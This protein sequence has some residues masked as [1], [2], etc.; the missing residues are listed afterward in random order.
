MLE[1]FITTTDVPLLAALVLGFLVAINPCQ[2][3]INISALTYIIKKDALS[4]DKWTNPL[5]YVLG[6]SITYTLMAW[7]LV[8]LIGG[9]KNI[10]AVQLALS[11]GEDIL[12]YAL[13]LMALFFLY[14]GLHTHHHEHGDDCHNCG[15]IIQRNGPLGALTL[16]LTLALAFC[17]ESAVF[18][19]GL[20]LPMSATSS[21]GLL[22]PPVFAIGAALP[23]FFIAFVM[24]K[25]T[26]K[27]KRLSHSLEHLQRVLNIVTALLFLGIALFILFGE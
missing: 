9:G 4:K 23:I 5:L 17:P 14:R 20:L 10:E 26:D 2:L 25:A 3:A 16:G 6:R 18:Y 8:C 11:K 19:F 21:V 15:Q 27:A 12:P 7:A 13:I 1:Q 22:L 24:Q